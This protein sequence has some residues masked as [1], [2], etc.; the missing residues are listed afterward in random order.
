M[1]EDF[2]QAIADAVARGDQVV[3][4]DGQG[5]ETPLTTRDGRTV[6]VKDGA[7]V[8]WMGMLSHTADR[9]EVRRPPAPS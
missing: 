1:A 7:G 4:V 2:H 5:R 8:G 3:H 6:Q 9:V